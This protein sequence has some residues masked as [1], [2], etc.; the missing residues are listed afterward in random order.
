MNG[1]SVGAP[2]Q[3]PNTDKPQGKGGSDQKG[4]SKEKSIL[5]LGMGEPLT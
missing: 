1:D 3:L 2:S 5:P 4:C